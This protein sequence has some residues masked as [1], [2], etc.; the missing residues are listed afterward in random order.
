ME[1]LVAPVALGCHPRGDTGIAFGY[2][3][4]V[5]YLCRLAQRGYR[6]LLDG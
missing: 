6:L 2:L 4:K 5:D 1:V 3:A